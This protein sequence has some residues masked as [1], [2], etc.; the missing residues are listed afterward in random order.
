MWCRGRSQRPDRLQCDRHITPSQ[1][2][3]AFLVD[4]ACD[5]GQDVVARLGVDGKE[6]EAGTVAALTRQ[7][8]RH[9]V[10]QK[11][12]R[13]LQQ[14]TGA[15]ACLGVSTGG[16]AVFEVPQQQQGIADDGVR[17]LALDV[18]H[19]ADAAGVV[20]VGASIEA[21]VVG[22]NGS[23]GHAWTPCDSSAG[24]ATG[25]TASASCS[26]VRMR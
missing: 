8:K 13:H 20:F 15:V 2:C 7:I 5:E 25:V 26:P 11:G 16:T 22:G 1:Q 3:L 19:K 18:C 24:V 12:V 10:A 6:D 17:A 23:G 21:L 9:H 14:Q 4:D